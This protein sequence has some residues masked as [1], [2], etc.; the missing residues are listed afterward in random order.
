MMLQDWRNFGG[1]LTWEFNKYWEFDDEFRINY[2][3]DKD[4][5][6]VVIRTPLCRSSFALEIYAQ[7]IYYL[8]IYYWKMS[9]NEFDCHRV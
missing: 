8:T 6:I 9:E 1:T 7:K 4:T 5:I 3:R 2:R